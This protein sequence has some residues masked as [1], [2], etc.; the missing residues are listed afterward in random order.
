[1]LITVVII[2]IVERNDEYG[3]FMKEHEILYIDISLKLNFQRCCCDSINK[4]E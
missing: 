4:M 1:M 3:N 2:T